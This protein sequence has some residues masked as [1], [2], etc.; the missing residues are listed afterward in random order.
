VEHVPTPLHLTTVTMAA[1]SQLPVS[2]FGNGDGHIIIVHEPGAARSTRAEVDTGHRTTD[3]GDSIGSLQE[4]GEEQALLPAERQNEEINE[5][6]GGRDTIESDTD[7]AV[8]SVSPRGNVSWGGGPSGWWSS[9][10]SKFSLSREEPVEEGREIDVEVGVEEGG[11]SQTREQQQQ[12]AASV[13]LICLETLTSED[14]RSGKAMSLDCGCR[15]ELALRHKD[16]AI[17]WSQVKDD[18][19]GGLPTCELCKKPVKNLPELPAREPANDEEGPE[20][21]I[22]EVYF[23]DP[24][25]FQQFVPSRADVVFDCVRVTWIAMIISILFFDASIGAALWT[26][27]IAGMAYIIMLRL[28]YKQHFEA[29]RA[30]AEQHAAA[31]RPHVPIVQVV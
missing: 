30:Y 10:R 27:L 11:T 12:T 25:Q 16:C 8:A 20:M 31:H 5:D 1:S 23:S 22:E 24:S 4:D 15:G 14:F 7:P 13:C 18:G 9:I 29:M 2:Q 19:R 26:G 28:L 6:V 17:K 21:T 3:A